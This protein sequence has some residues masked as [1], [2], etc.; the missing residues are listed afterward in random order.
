MWGR[1]EEGKIKG[2]KTIFQHFE[3]KVA[4]GEEPK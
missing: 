3:F 1:G 2:W 4:I